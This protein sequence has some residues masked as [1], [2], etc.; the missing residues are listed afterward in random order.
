MK[1]KW[2]KIGAILAAIIILGVFVF[3]LKTNKEITEERVYQYDKQQP[4][5]VQV[6]TLSR[7]GINLESLFSGTFEPNKETKL[8]ADIQG[9]IVNVQ[10]DAGSYVQKGQ[11]LI[12]LDNSLLQLQLQS[13]E[14]QIEGLEADV[15]RY[16]VLAQSDAIQGVQLEKAELGLRSAK[17]QEATLREQINKTTVKA[18]FSGIVTAKLTEEGA[19]S[20]PGVPLLQISDLATL[21]FTVNVSEN[22]LNKVDMNR[23]YAITS[24]AYPELELTGKATLI[25]SKSN[26]GGSFPIQFEVKNTPEAKI[27]SGMFGKVSL[28]NTLQENG[29]LIR[30]SAIV[31]TSDK[32]QVYLVENGKANLKNITVSRK[33]G[34]NTVVLE[35]LEDGDVIVTQ[36]LINLFDGAN[37]VI[38]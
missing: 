23:E 26:R 33:I 30:S 5:P 35:G 3:K 32:P 15:N 27:K 8:S 9:K 13:V 18:P 2:K 1:G 22:D 34:S 29:I 7:T 11:S 38:Q 25:G 36:G 24:D 6:E 12:Q 20:A 4:I 28:N 37:V 14:V 17:I 21:K 19:F 16:T 31:G 10:V